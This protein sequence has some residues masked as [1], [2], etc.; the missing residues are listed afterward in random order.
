MSCRYYLWFLQNMIGDIIW[1]YYVGTIR[2]YDQ[3][4]LD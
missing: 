1:M 2:F 3:L 4:V